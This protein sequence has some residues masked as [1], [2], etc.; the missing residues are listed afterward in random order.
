[1]L[2]RFFANLILSCAAVLFLP[3]A[4]ECCHTGSHT[5]L[6]FLSGI[7]ADDR[8]MS[9]HHMAMTE[10]VDSSALDQSPAPGESTPIPTISLPAG[11]E[12]A[13]SPG[14]GSILVPRPAIV[15]ADA[16]RLAR[17][18]TSTRLIG[19]SDRPASPP[20]RALA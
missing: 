20:P 9:H 14:V 8:A 2:N 16:H 18:D 6:E 15:A 10:S 12:S 1:M 13:Q 19:R 4:L 11:S 7:S 17:A 5:T 3:Q